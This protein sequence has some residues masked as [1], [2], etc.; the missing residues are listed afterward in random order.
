MRSINIA[1]VVR[2]H[3]HKNK[4]LVTPCASL[5]QVNKTLQRLKEEKTQPKIVFSRKNIGSGEDCFV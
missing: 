3:P 4:P 2:P 5:V 1:Y